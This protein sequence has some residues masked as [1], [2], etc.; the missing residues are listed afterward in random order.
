MQKQYNKCRIGKST[1][2][3]EIVEGVLS[4]WKETK[5][6]SISKAKKSNG[7]DSTTFESAAVLPRN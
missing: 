2:T 7:R 1:F 5:H 3:R 4:E 6:E